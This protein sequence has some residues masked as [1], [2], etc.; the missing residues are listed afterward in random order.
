MKF[1][2]THT[3]L[4]DLLTCYYSRRSQ[5]SCHIRRHLAGW[6]HDQDRQFQLMYHGRATRGCT[7]GGA[8]LSTALS[9]GDEKHCM[10]CVWTGVFLGK[11]TC[12]ARTVHFAH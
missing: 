8:T 5:P 9:G 7:D 6:P 3:R 1:D 10:D 11:A 12:E 4:S 2:A